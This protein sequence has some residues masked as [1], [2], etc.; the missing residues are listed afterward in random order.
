MSE[1]PILADYRHF[2]GTNFITPDHSYHNPYITLMDA[3]YQGLLTGIIPTRQ[4][5]IYCEEIKCINDIDANYRFIRKY[6]STYWYYYTLAIRLFTFNNM[7][8]EIYFFFKHI[9]VSRV[10]IQLQSHINSVETH[11]IKDNPL[12]SVI[13][14]TLDRYKYLKDVLED[15][16][17]QD[18]DNF[19]V[20][21]CDQSQPFDSFFYNNWKFKLILIRQ[22]EKA[23]WQARNTCIKRA[24]GDYLLLFDDD[25]RVESDWIRRHLQ[26]LDFYN[27]EISAGVTHTINGNPVSLKEQYFHLSDVFDTGNAM[28]RRGVFERTGLFDRQFEKQRMGDG[29]FGLRAMLNGYQIVS[30]PLAKRIHLKVETGGL[31][32]MGSWDALRPGK[33]LAPRP[34]PSVLY[35]FRKYFGNSSAIWYIVQ[36]VPTSFMPYRFK[37][38]RALKLLQIFLVPFLLPVILFVVSLSWYASSKKLNIGALIEPLPGNIE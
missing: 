30:N 3:A 19:E 20:V 9:N 15:L 34:V 28:V 31:R 26:C 22:S 1:A 38:I 36:N 35:F 10:K 24:G 2:D 37:N 7:F 18:Y 12:V 25:S 29:E 32:N 8:K 16:E 27:V 4:N 21:V 33:L 5:A 17:N 13:I 14:P 11:L 6:F 23:L